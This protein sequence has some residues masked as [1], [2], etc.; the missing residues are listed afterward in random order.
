MPEQ[1]QA[2]PALHGGFYWF[3]SP[4]LANVAGATGVAACH[5]PAWWHL[6][7]WVRVLRLRRL[8]SLARI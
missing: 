6:A 1:T 7:Q 5:R 4:E 2:A 3:G 8:A